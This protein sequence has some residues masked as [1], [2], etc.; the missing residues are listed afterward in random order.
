MKIAVSTD[1]VTHPQDLAD[2]YA[3]LQ[4]GKGLIVVIPSGATR[5]VH[6]VSNR[7]LLVR[8]SLAQCPVPYPSTTKAMYKEIVRR[9]YLTDEDIAKAFGYAS[10]VSMK[11]SKPFQRGRVQ[12][13]TI[14]L[15]KLFSKT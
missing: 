6:M 15:H 9:A 5:E 1:F 12:E 3:K 8:Q 7:S 14:N 13:L 2:Q 10:T 11:A 4:K